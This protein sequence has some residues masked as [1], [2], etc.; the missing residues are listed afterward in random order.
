MFPTRVDLSDHRS[1]TVNDALIE[2]ADYVYNDLQAEGSPLKDSHS[3]EETY[4]YRVCQLENKEIT[5]PFGRGWAPPRSYR[6]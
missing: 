3:H 5:D 1:Q 2:K 6:N 4:N